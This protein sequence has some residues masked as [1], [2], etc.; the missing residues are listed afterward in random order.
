MARDGVNG[1]ADLR[2][3]LLTTDD[4]A[5]ANWLRVA[6]RE[7]R[8]G[9]GR[10]IPK[11]E[12]LQFTPHLANVA[13]AFEPAEHHLFGPVANGQTESKPAEI[14][15]HGLWPARS[16]YRASYILWGKGIKAGRKPAA[17]MLTV[18]PRLAELLGVA[19]PFSGPP[20]P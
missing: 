14:G 9:V 12:L 7:Q 15:V 4:P 5:A 2:F 10:E 17:S 19:Y 18:A 3:G 13:A 6:S 16:D 11:A 20:R 8:H 1:K